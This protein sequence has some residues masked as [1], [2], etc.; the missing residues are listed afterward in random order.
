MNC[1][2]CRNDL[3]L[4]EEW[5]CDG[6]E[7]NDGNQLPPL[8]EFECPIC[9]GEDPECDTCEEDPETG[10]RVWALRQCPNRIVD[11]IDMRL[12]QTA[13]IFA[14]C[15]TLP[16]EGAWMDQANAWTQAA[17]VILN[18]RASYQEAAREKARAE[19]EARRK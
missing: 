8:V 7:D 18:A 5:Q 17:G 13:V 11:A 1:Q 3:D 4:R 15:N 9:G 16:A 2:L 10:E 6:P 19:A 12:V 14:D